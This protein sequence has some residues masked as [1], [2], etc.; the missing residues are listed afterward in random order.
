MKAILF[1][2]DGTI[3]DTIPVLTEA[4][5]T[6]LVLLG[7][8]A[9]HTVKDFINHGARE[10]IRRAMPEGERDDKEKVDRAFELYENCYR[11]VYLHTEKP[12]AGIAEVVAKIHPAARV[13]ILSNKPDE[14]TQGLARQMFQNGEID[15]AVGFEDGKPGK[16]NRYLPQKLARLLDVPLSDCLLIGDSEVDIQTAK[17]AGMAFVG[18]GWGF[19]GTKAL[20][21]AGADVVAPTPGDLWREIEKF[22]ERTINK[23]EGK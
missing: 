18:A 16:P 19:L 5:N 14:M 6:T 22:L 13:G 3:A 11:R 1:D 23:G 20:Y 15:A 8:P 10:L 9:H 17:N 4:V 2:F 21:A 7:Y 12:Y